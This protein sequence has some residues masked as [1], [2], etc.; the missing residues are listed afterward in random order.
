MHP[1]RLIEIVMNSLYALSRISFSFHAK[2]GY[3][4]DPERE[5]LIEE[6]EFDEQ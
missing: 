5:R 4:F 3:D 6:G 1:A 2:L